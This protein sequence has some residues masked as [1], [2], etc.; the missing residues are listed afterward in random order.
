MRDGANLHQRVKVLLEDLFAADVLGVE[1]PADIGEAAVHGIF[2]EVEGRIAV[3]LKFAIVAEGHAGALAI[4]P[5]K[6]FGG[7]GYRTVAVKVIVASATT[8]IAGP[9]LFRKVGCIARHR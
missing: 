8:V 2:E 4:V 5:D 3:I 9:G 6:S 7:V 1:I